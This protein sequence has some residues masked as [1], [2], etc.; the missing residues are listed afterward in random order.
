MTNTTGCAICNKS[1]LA[2]LLLRPSPLARITETPRPNVV[3]I[4]ASLIPPGSELIDSVDADIQGIMPGTPP[5]ESRMVL[6]TLRAGYVYIYLEKPSI[7]WIVYRVTEQGDMVPEEHA[8]FDQPKKNFTCLD[9]KHNS[10][11]MK[12]VQI[13]QAHLASTIWIAFSANLW[14]TTVRERNKKNPL[15]MQK[16]DLLTPS[17]NTFLPSAANLKK[18]VLECS[19][20]DFTIDKSTGHDFAFTPIGN[21]DKMAAELAAAASNHK[22]TKGKELA[23]VLSDPCGLATELNALRIRRYHLLHK[24]FVKPKYEHP[25]KSSNALLGLKNMVVKDGYERAAKN[26]MHVVTHERFEKSFKDSKDPHLAGAYWHPMPSQLDKA[27]KPLGQVWTNESAKLYEEQAKRFRDANWAN[28]KSEF[29]EGARQRWHDDF[30]AAMQALHLDS[31]AKFENDWWR[32]CRH[33]RYKSYFTEHFDENDENSPKEHHSAG[34]CYGRETTLSKTPQPYTNGAILDDYV[35]QITADI[36]QPEMNMLRTLGANQKVVIAAIEGFTAIKGT[37]DHLHG[38]RNDKLYDFCAALVQGAHSAHNP[39][40][41]Q[42]AIVQYSWLS[43][44]LGDSITGYSLLVNHSLV[45]AALAIGMRH[46]GSITGSI[47]SGLRSWTPTRKLLDFCHAYSKIQVATDYVHRSVVARTALTTPIFIVKRFSFAEGIAKLGSRG[48]MLTPTRFAAAQM[49]GHLDLELITDER[50]MRGFAGNID[51]AIEGGAGKVRTGPVSALV[52]TAPTERSV[53][54]SAA[55]WDAAW[56]RRL[57]ANAAFWLHEGFRDGNAIIQSLEGKL[58]LGV[59]LLNGLQLEKN[60]NELHSKGVWSKKHRDALL[61]AVDAGASVIGGL[62][63]VAEVAAKVSITGRL[64]TEIASKSILIHSL[65]TASMGLGAFAG[66]VGAISQFAKMKDAYQ[67]GYAGASYFY[68]AS[69]LAFGG[70]ATTGTLATIG[71]IAEYRLARVPTDLIA[72]RLA[73]RYGAAAVASAMG[74][75][76]SGWGIVLLAAGVAFE[77]CAVMATPSE[78]Q[79]W[80][81]RSYFGYGKGEQPKFAP[82]NW[83]DEEK[84]LQKLVQ[85]P[86]EENSIGNN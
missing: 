63:Q 57:S 47:N 37:A 59:C 27:G 1:S 23:I 22:T 16:I 71:A 44:S 39:N 50:E 68:F 86:K 15:Q 70:T 51:D 81:Q 84:E 54:F 48:T 24:E 45:A 60:L 55:T 8:L 34:L 11:G 32:V 18:R 74:L 33:P 6:R 73:Q 14:N 30:D 31:T 62:C 5:T 4:V 29:D 43:T 10:E 21:V 35:E 25:L 26:L 41:V 65:R 82:G 38:Q 79:K 19:L 12:L 42:K 7:K 61:G 72:R 77:I 75:S 2:L 80:V 58:A 83:K 69:A 28:I 67:S 52:V 56:N 53:R 20:K 9:K 85:L 49:A 76:L 46:A 17:P 78:M 3:P 13:P 40:K 36:K 66:L 64:G